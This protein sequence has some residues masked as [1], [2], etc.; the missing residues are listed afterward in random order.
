MHST[1]SYR[2]V[3]IRDLTLN[4]IIKFM[5]KTKYQKA[6]QCMRLVVYPVLTWP[7]SSHRFFIRKPSPGYLGKCVY[8]VR[9]NASNGGSEGL[10][11]NNPNTP[12]SLYLYGRWD[13]RNEIVSCL[14]FGEDKGNVVSYA[15][16]RILLGRGG[17]T[18]QVAR[19]IVDEMYAR[20]RSQVV[21]TMKM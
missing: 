20:M 10:Q 1:I 2:V 16:S 3:N 18:W 9:T 5:Q 19:D 7:P 17:V 14:V 4:T 21:L 13:L 12:T 6:P 8:S 11:F 15:G